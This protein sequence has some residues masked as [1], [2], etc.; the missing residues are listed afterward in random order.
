MESE[1]D[2]LD[3]GNTMVGLTAVGTKPAECKS[4]TSYNC[5]SKIFK[6]CTRCNVA[7]PAACSAPAVSLSHSTKSTPFLI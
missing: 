6:S 3:D 4:S 7:K 2:L 5:I 1:R